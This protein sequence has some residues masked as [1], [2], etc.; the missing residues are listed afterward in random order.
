MFCK[1]MA[2]KCACFDVDFIVLPPG[3]QSSRNIRLILYSYFKFLKLENFSGKKLSGRETL[4][5][6]GV[7]VLF[8]GIYD[9]NEMR[10]LT[11]IT[12]SCRMKEPS[13]FLTAGPFPI[14]NFAFVCRQL[15]KIALFSS[16]A[17]QKLMH[18]QTQSMEEHHKLQ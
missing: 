11:K 16:M 14:E 2:F 7:Y 8:G 9:R 6:S 10:D 3:L 5:W 12:M 4:K 18:K 13:R 1:N 17:T 15:S